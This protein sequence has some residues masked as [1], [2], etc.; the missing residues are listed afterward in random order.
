M[1]NILNYIKKYTF[2]LLIDLLLCL[3]ITLGNYFFINTSICKIILFI[4]NIILFI[5]TGYQ[6]GKNT[7]KR[8][9]IEGILTGTIMCIIFFILGLIFYKERVA[10]NALYYYLFLISGA[11]FGGI[12]GKNK[13]NDS[14][15]VG[16]N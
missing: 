5:I 11:T 8:G 12:I 2:F 14:N 3:L 4:S 1:K 9:Y 15:F 10:I 16:K 6:N 13:K 7:N